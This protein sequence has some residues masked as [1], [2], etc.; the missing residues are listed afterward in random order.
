[1]KICNSPNIIVIVYPP[2][3][4]G[5]FLNY[6]F[7]HFF[8]ETVKI[9]E[10]GQL[11]DTVGT[12]HYQKTYAKAINSTNFDDYQLEVSVPFSKSEKI[13]LLYDCGTANESYSHLDTCQQVHKK[14]PN[15]IIIKSVIDKQSIAVFCNTSSAKTSYLFDHIGPLNQWNSPQEDYSIREYWSLWFHSNPFYFTECFDFNVVNVQLSKL[16]TNPVKTITNIAD[17][18]NLTIINHNKLRVFCRK[19]IKTQLPYFKILSIQRR[20]MRCINNNINLDISNITNL[21]DQ[22]YINYCIEREFNVTIP[23]Y[24]YR[25]WFKNT[26]EIKEMLKNYV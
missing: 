12:M 10:T 2:G 3:G 16:I 6:V 24:N 26:N 25:D 4:Y 22:G 8:K 9:E 13:V 5:Y 15:S 21:R 20:I 14:F 17:K 7:T 1:M 19:W 23:V 18:L 11:F